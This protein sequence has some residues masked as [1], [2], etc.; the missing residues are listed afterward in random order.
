MTRFI[1][2]ETRTAIANKAQADLFLSIHANLIQRFAAHGVET[3]YLNFTSQPDALRG[4]G[5]REC[6]ERSVDLIS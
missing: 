1:P 5:A 4:R 2:L 3:Y 6:G